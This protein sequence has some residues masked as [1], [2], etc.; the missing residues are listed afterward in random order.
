M[1]QLVLKNIKI[2]IAVVLST[3]LTVSCDKN[4]NSLIPNVPVSLT[5]N[6]NIINDLTVP[7]NSHFFPNVGYGGII[8]YCELPGS[9]YAF[10]ATCTHEI[11]TTCKVE[12]EGILGTC[13]CCGSQYVFVGGTPSKGPA[14]LPLKQYNVAVIN[15][16]TIRVYN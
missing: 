11:S 2:F 14:A 8:V 10:D 15:S 6:L 1:S 3:V 5:I 4:Q 7:G 12:N 16:S 9:W 13:S